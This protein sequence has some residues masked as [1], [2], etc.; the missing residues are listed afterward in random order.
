MDSIE[1]MIFSVSVIVALVVGIFV[2]LTVTRR[3]A[4]SQANT[5]LEK[6]K[7]EA[8][9]LKNNE[10]IKG[11]EEGLSIKSEAE[12]QANQRLSKVQAEEGSQTEATRA[13]GEATASRCA[14]QKS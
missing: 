14:T 7:L 11:K 8:E 6:A 3:N 12:K 2:T 9:V 13:S 10:V 4:K 5:I 1:V